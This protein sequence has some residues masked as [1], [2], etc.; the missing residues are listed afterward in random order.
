MEIFIVRELIVMGLNL[1]QLI[2]AD[3]LSGAE[4]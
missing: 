3:F 4:S 2:S 1:L